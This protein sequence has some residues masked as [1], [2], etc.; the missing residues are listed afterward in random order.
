MSGMQSISN[1]SREMAREN[2]EMA[3]EKSWKAFFSKFVGTLIKHLLPT[4]KAS[5]RLTIEMV[6][7]SP[8]TQFEQRRALSIRVSTTMSSLQIDLKGFKQWP[9]A[10]S[11]CSWVTETESHLSLSVEHLLGFRLVFRL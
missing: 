11:M 1:L 3:M 4:S 9:C 10:I 5:T 6:P 7:E 8:F 2:Q